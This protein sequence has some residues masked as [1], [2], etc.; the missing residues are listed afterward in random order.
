M[1]RLRSGSDKQRIDHRAVHQA[2]VAGAGRD[3]EAVGRVDQT[4]EAA[5]AEA[6]ERAFVVPVGAHRIDHVGA[7]E[8]LLDEL[9]ISAG[10]C[11]RSASIITTTSPCSGL[12]AGGQCCFLAEVAGQLKDAKARASCPAGQHQRGGVGAAVVDQDDFP[13]ARRIPPVLHTAAA[14]GEPGCRPR[15]GR[16]P[17]MTRLASR[18]ERSFGC[19]TRAPR[20]RAGWLGPGN[21]AGVR[22]EDSWTTGRDACGPLQQWMPGASVVGRALT[23]T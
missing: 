18:T 13:G 6:L 11:C 15:C 14:T 1:K 20:R 22:G 2:E 8:P 3:L 10:A 4:I 16:A 17:R 19:Q 21:R 9:G 12:Q 7:G 23:A 5:R